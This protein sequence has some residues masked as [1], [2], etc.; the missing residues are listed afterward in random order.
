MKAALIQMKVQ[1]ENDENLV[2]ACALISQAA[3]AGADLI[4]LPEMF[5][6]PYETKNF[7]VYAQQEK[8]SNWQILSECAKKSRI[9]LV[10]GSMPERAG[11]Q[12]FNTSYVFDRQG[13]QIAKHRKMHLFD[14]D[15]RGGQHF[16]ESET[17]TAGSQITVFDTEFG[18]MGLMICFD[19]RFPELSRL[20]ALRGARAILVPAAFNLTTGPAHWELNF[21]SRA[22][23]NQVFL[24]G[25][26]PARDMQ[27]SYHAYGNSLVVSPWGNILA[28]LDEQEGILYCDIE[29]RET[30][31]VREQL[32]LLKARRTDIYS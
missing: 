3:Q 2:T 22:V 27:S 6:C 21:R 14:I 30:E 26:S 8:G 11:E 18:K 19:I 5:C 4:M 24:L 28:K 12:I 9:Y 10:A 23:D 32:P 7:P 15:I 29:L 20:L 16:C 17:L 25:C 31:E 13:V 1:K